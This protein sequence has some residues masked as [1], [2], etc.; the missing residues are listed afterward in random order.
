MKKQ[1]KIKPVKNN[2]DRLKKFILVP[3]QALF[4]ALI[5]V[6]FFIFRMS[7]TLTVES[8]EKTTKYTPSF[9]ELSTGYYESDCFRT[10]FKN[11][12][13]AVARYI[14]FREQLET[15]GDYDGSKVIYVGKFYHRNDAT[16]YEG[17][18]AAYHLDDLIFWAQRGV[19][20]DYKLFWS[21][22]SYQDFFEGIDSTDADYITSTSKT[23]DGENV[24]VYASFAA[25]TNRYLTVDGKKLEE[26]VDNAEEY[27]SLATALNYTINTLYSN[28]REYLVYKD[29]FVE[30]VSNIRYR[31][32]LT[33]DD[34]KTIYTNVPTLRLASAEGK[35]S[36]VFKNFGEYL[37]TE[38]GKIAFMTNTGLI[39][40]DVKDI[41]LGSEYAYAFPDDTTLWISLDTSLTAADVFYEDFIAYDR[42]VKLI[43]WIVSLGVLSMI[44]FIAI[45]VWLVTFEKKRLS[46]VGAKEELSDFEKLPLEVSTLIFILLALVFY[47]GESLLLKNADSFLRDAGFYFIPVSVILA[48]D[49][50]ILL[51][52][53]YG[54]VRRIICHNVFERSLIGLIAPICRRGFV[55]IRNRFWKA[56]DGAG[57]AIRTWITFLFFMMFNV[58]WALMLFFSSHPFISFFV[59]L[60]FDVTTG[61]ILFSR[62]LERKK[63]VDGIRTINQ[64]NHDYQIDAKKMHGDNR[65]LAEAVNNIGQGI[66]DAV[67]ISIKD[68]KMK[69][70]L[71]TNVSHDI[72]TPLTSIINYVDLLKRENID[73]ERVTKYIKVLDEKSQRLKQLTFDLVEASKITSGNITL[74]FTK[75]NF[76]EFIIQTLGEFEEKFEE[77]GFTIVKNLPNEPVYISADPRR[78]W[79]VVENLYNN[80]CKYALDNTR[81]YLDVIVTREKDGETVIMSVKNVSSQQLNIPADELTERFIRGD[82]SRSTEGSGLGL[83]IAKSLT[84]A[85]HGT[86]DIYLDGD[87]F[88]VILTFP[89]L[90][91]EE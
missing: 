36:D 16:P 11:A 64:G 44:A 4:G 75:I 91:S 49:I 72:K 81:V 70:D 87:L 13:E 60:V 62:N 56:Y 78:L 31:F 5:A 6:C 8:F 34:K 53:F 9:Q 88:K 86:F 3:V 38:P 15:D 18:D 17:P 46:Y 33:V 77:H 67:T 59:L 45:A 57:V 50:L 37:Y 58:F 76:V 35:A 84:T 28:Y 69:A 61:A 14:V 82:V 48:L 83:S 51:I 7:S 63:I 80:I 24:S 39:Y 10:N 12:V 54:F 23:E 21:E 19:S 47:F 89:V 65:E 30:D 25:I 68:E 26:C 43:P 32:S 40:D 2:R 29:K 73:N 74:E 66:R 79:R 55:K 41:I 20:K 42:T 22:K 71:I 1:E 27:D 85:Q 90:K 52:F